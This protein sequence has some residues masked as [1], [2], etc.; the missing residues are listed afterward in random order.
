[1][2]AMSKSMSIEQFSCPKCGN[3]MR[4]GRIKVKLDL[5]FDDGMTVETEAPFTICQTCHNMQTFPDVY[6]KG[7][8]H[9]LSRE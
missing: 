7:R 6:K 8:I 1:M 3:P 5:V 9:D 2:Q 4:K